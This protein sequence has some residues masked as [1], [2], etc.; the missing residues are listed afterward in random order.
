MVIKHKQFTKLLMGSL[1]RKLARV[2]KYKN[3][4]RV[5]NESIK[6]NELEI[7]ALNR[8]QMWEEGIVDVNNPQAILNYAPGT[9]KQKKKR[10]RYKRTDHITLK[11]AG[12]FHDKMKLVIKATEFF[13][14]S[15]DFKWSK[16]SSGE[17]GG[18][19]FENALG[20]TGK[21]KSELRKLIK[22]D[23][24]LGFKHAIQGS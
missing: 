12:S 16:F 19:R 20:L 22:S 23:L 2:R 9:I 24:I 21:S 11:W 3:I 13:I 4:H 5:I 7:L 18:G 6:D 14:T 1:N 8:D 15:K 10:A 17:W